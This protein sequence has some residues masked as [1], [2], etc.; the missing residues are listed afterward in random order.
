MVE[1]KTTGPAGGR[2]SQAMMTKTRFAAFAL[3]IVPTFAFAL[4]LAIVE[5]VAG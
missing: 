4:S 1:Q 3:T 5:L 2:G